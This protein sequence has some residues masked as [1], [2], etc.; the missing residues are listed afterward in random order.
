MPLKQSIPNLFGEMLQRYG[1]LMELAVEQQTYRVEHDV[2]GNLRFIAEELG[3]LKEGP[4]DVVELHSSALGKKTSE[5]SHGKAQTYVEEGR[6]MV[7]ELIG[8]LASYYS[9]YSL[10][11]TTMKINDRPI[12]KGN[13]E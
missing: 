12:E 7:H 11:A 6:V 2:S 9:T 4:S 5:T 13:D 8:H 1:D 3:Y 10:G